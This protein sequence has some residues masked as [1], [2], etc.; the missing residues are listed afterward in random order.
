MKK[1][2]LI[3]I[4]GGIAVYKI[5]TLVNLLI[6]EGHDVKI[7]MTQSATKFVSALTFKTL[8]NNRIYLDMFELDSSLAHISLAKWADIFLIA[9][10]TCNTISKM[11]YGIADNLL[12]SVFMAMPK[13]KY[14]IIS[15]AMNSEM[16]NNEILQ[17]NIK[18]LSKNKKYIFI[19]PRKGVLACRDIGEGKIADNSEILEVINQYLK[20]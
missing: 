18:R 4:T 5:C 7:I 9:P 20:K 14:I 11:S 6:K 15:P 3:G 10:A 13:D 16:W 2:I 19:Q 8:S 1:N 17:E 12:T